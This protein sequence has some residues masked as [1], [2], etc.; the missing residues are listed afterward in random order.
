[1]LLFNYV[2]A[3]AHDVFVFEIPSKYRNIIVVRSISGFLGIQGWWGSVKYMP[4]SIANCIMFSM[5]IW[6]TLMAACY[7]KEK[8]TC[9]DVVAVFS[10]FAGVLLI[11][12]PVTEER[13]G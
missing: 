13:E 4:V 8:L 5:P 9:F 1:M 7:L 12:I 3:R 11:N 10:A 2:F 6:A